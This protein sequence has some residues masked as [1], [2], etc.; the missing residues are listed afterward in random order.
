LHLEFQI[1]RVGIY[2]TWCLSFSFGAEI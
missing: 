2:Q 1:R